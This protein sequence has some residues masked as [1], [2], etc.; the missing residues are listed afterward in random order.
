MC[1]DC[2]ICR[3]FIGELHDSEP[4]CKK[5]HK[6]F[7]LESCKDFDIN[8]SLCGNFFMDQDTDDNGYAIGPA[9]AGCYRGCDLFPGVCEKFD[10]VWKMLN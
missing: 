1:F 9:I 7:T 3:N 10:D 4:D 5:G 6:P 8:C 2:R